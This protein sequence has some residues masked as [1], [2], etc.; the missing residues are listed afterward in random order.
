M[1]S[2]RV[3]A[4]STAHYH[5]TSL[6]L[7]YILLISTCLQLG[8]CATQPAA[9]GS[10]NTI[11]EKTPEG[12]LRLNI[13]RTAQSMLGKPYH[14]GGATP[15]GFDCSGLVFYSY[16]MAG[17]N[18]PRTTRAQYKQTKPVAPDKLLPGDVLF[19]RIDGGISHVG[20]YQGGSTFIHAPVKGKQVA[21]DSIN[22]RYWKA[23]FARGGRLL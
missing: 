9:I 15:R 14:Y 7:F 10:G 11:S 19:F 5:R 23:H 12:K 2:A 20:I 17:I 4:M 13:L 8:G 16:R 22:S 1:N 3:K 6:S 21:R 18:V